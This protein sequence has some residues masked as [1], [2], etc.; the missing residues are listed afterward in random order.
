MKC[1]IFF[2]FGACL[3]PFPAR[4]PSLLSPCLFLYHYFARCCGL[5]N[6]QNIGRVWNYGA[7]A[8]TVFRITRAGEKKVDHDSTWDIQVR[9]RVS[10]SWNSFSLYLSIYLT[11]YLLFCSPF[12]SVSF[13]FCFLN[14]HAIAAHISL[15]LAVVPVH[16]SAMAKW[17]SKCSE[18]W[19]R[20]VQLKRLLKFD[21]SPN[22]HLKHHFATSS[23]HF[24]IHN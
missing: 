9:E 6:L 2:P 18:K 11:I 21:D 22:Y 14:F 4:M 24:D 17:H 15:L 13:H 12:S 16:F 3:L 19:R 5:S 23:K 1:S 10:I 7:L 8:H 20:F